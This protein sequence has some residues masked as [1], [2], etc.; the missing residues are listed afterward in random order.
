MDS[1]YWTKHKEKWIQSNK[2][3]SSMELLRILAIIMIIFHHFVNWSHSPFLIEDISIQKFRYELIHIWWKIWVNLF[4]LISWYYLSKSNT[5][6]IKKVIKFRCEC[7][8]YSLWIFLIYCFFSHT[9]ITI[10]NLIDASTPITSYHLWFT[11]PYIIMY[12]LHPLLNIVCS[13]FNKKSHK[14][15]LTLLMLV[16]IIVP[17]FHPVW[18]E[19]FNN[20]VLWFISIYFVA[21]YIRC[22]QSN[23]TSNKKEIKKTLIESCLLLYLLKV[24]II[25]IEAKL[26]IIPTYIH[27]ALTEMKPYSITVFTISI[28]LFLYFTTIK[29]KYKKRINII[30]STTF[31]IYLI[32]W[33]RLLKP[34]MRNSWFKVQDSRW[35]LNVI[36]YSIAVVMIIFCICA[37]IDLLRQYFLER[38]FL[39]FI[40]KNINRI[41]KWLNKILSKIKLLGNPF[42]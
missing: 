1:V 12:L 39:K 10:W 26:T 29:I 11:A 25:I 35:S 8:F 18:W 41:D 14:K 7:F 34:I 31:W 17:I 3:D 20:Q 15:F 6:K 16:W 42:I 28:L 38:P 40:D 30:A 27:N 21:N 37:I 23:F 19:D 32:H 5:V 4:I 22:Y 24:I 33:N 2:R 13:S 36:P 9:K